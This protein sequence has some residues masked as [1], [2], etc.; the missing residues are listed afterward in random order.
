VIGFVS[1]YRRSLRGRVFGRVRFEAVI[2]RDSAYS[3]LKLAFR[4]FSFWW[5]G[6]PFP[7]VGSMLSFSREQVDQGVRPTLTSFDSS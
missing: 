3:A 7:L 5:G 2:Q 4:S 1:K 6:P